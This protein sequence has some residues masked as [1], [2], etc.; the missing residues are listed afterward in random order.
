MVRIQVWRR[1]LVR[2][3]SMQFPP[4]PY[5]NRTAAFEWVKSVETPMVLDA[6]L[7]LRQHP[8]N[9]VLEAFTQ[10]RD[11]GT[12]RALFDARIASQVEQPYRFPILM[13]FKSP[14]NWRAIY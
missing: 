1:D 11:S 13:L 8:P 7:R 6:C 9:P 10:V 12:K 5:S 3:E 4:F 2:L 14:V